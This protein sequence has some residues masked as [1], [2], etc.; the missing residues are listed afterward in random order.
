M[1]KKQQARRS[2]SRSSDGSRVVRIVVES[3][4]K[5]RAKAPSWLSKSAPKKKAAA[6]R[7]KKAAPK[8]TTVRDFIR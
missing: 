6:S 4:P 2:S 3:A 8:G 5:A 7:K 1:A